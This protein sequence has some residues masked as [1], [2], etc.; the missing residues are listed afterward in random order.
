MVTPP[1]PVQAYESI[2]TTTVGSGGQA[3]ISFTSIPS[4]FKH[5][6][7]RILARSNYAVQ[8]QDYL[9]LRYNSDT[10]AN[11][12]V[13]NLFGDGSTTTAQGFASQNENWIQRI[14]AA[15]ATASAFGVAVVDILDYADTSKY[16][17]MRNLGGVDNNGS[18]RVYLTSGS[19]QN[20]AAIN[21]IDI[22]AGDGSSL[23]QHSSFA[24][25]GIKG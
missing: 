25:Y 16:K 15:G 13:H 1:A 5:L 20:T 24:L 19:W 7:I 11:Y 2:A 4:T 8:L 22:T 18:G 14:S 6:Q 12:S 9:K 17:T 21:R 23:D 10:G 3:T